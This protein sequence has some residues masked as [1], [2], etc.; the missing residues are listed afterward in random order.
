M[1]LNKLIKLIKKSKAGL[2]GFAVGGLAVAV[3]IY[4][5]S[6]KYISTGSFFVTRAAVNNN[7]F[8]TYEGYYSQQVALSY[9]NTVVALLGTTDIQ[10]R[11][12]AELGIPI[13]ETN[14][15]KYS[16]YI[17]ATKSGPQLVTLT[18]K[19]NTYDSSKQL[20]EALSNKLLDANQR[21]RSNG[22]E[23]LNI[24]KVSP[25]PVVKKEFRSLWINIPVGALLGFTCG[26]YLLLTGKNE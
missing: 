16:K 15:R 19:G 4:V 12:L 14:L 8:F 18:V 20:W 21:L 17:K 11:A 1:E 6:D 5:L 24:A 9:T 3:V 22:D 25:I 2:L 23:K 7:Q 13:N 10:S 26:L